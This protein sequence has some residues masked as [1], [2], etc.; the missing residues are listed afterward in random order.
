M[1]P[2]ELAATFRGTRAGSSISW[3]GTLG[4]YDGTKRQK[5]HPPRRR[6]GD[7]PTPDVRPHD[8][9]RPSKKV[10][11]DT[12]RESR[13]PLLVGDCRLTF[14]RERRLPSQPAEVGDEERVIELSCNR[15]LLQEAIES[16]ARG[17]GSLL[18]R[19]GTFLLPDKLH[20][21]GGVEVSIPDSENLS[22]AAPSHLAFVGVAPVFLRKE[23]YAA[24]A[25][26]A[27]SVN[28]F[29]RSS[30]PLRGP[31]RTR[32]ASWWLTDGT[33][34]RLREDRIRAITICA[35]EARS[36]WESTP[37]QNHLPNALPKKAVIS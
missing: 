24:Q 35:R 20:C 3:T 33:R 14:L 32:K 1:G 23:A 2:S 25:V 6:A 31:M 9:G 27:L 26:R 29:A 12:G 37:R 13:S 4:R 7:P 36:G 15:S 34:S 28:R 5:A 21:Q 18:C 22:H 19:I 16:L 8:P 10:S 11:S 30:S 17:R